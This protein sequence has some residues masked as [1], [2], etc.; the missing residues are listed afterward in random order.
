MDGDITEKEKMELKKSLLKKFEGL[1][2]QEKE[3]L[4]S[5]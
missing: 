1:N 3:L 5:L 4:K 2:D